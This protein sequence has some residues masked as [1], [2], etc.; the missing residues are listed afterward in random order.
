MCALGN[1]KWTKNISILTIKAKII[2]KCLRREPLHYTDSK[3]QWGPS[4]VSRCY[5]FSTTGHWIASPSWQRRV[6]RKKLDK[7]QVFVTF[8][9]QFTT[10]F[11]SILNLQ[12]AVMKALGKI[13]ERALAVTMSGRYLLV[14]I[15]EVT[16]K[17]SP[18]SLSVWLCSDCN[19]VFV[20][21][22]SIV[23]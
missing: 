22:T 23:Q 13:R 19:E 4:I 3:S 17:T 15:D 14:S 10:K 18:R 16:F 21:I 9:M 11:R 2:G 12:Q 8:H 20:T 7:Y 5:I 1:H 6:K